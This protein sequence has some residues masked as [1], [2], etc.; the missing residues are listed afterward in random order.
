MLGFAEEVERASDLARH[1]FP[2]KCGGAPAWLEP[3]G[4]PSSEELRCAASGRPLDFLLQVYAPD[5]DA[6]ERAFHR[7][8]FVFATP[9]GALAA[10]PGAV[11]AFRCQLGRANAFYGYEPA[12][13]EQTSPPALSAAQAAA[14]DARLGGWEGA[15]DGRRYRELELVVEPEPTDEEDFDA[16]LEDGSARVVPE[17][18]LPGAPDEE[19]LARMPE[20][21]VLDTSHNPER[22][23]FADFLT[24]TQRA[25]EQV[26]RYRF[27]DG[28]R[29]LWPSPA[30]VPKEGDVPPCPRCGSPRRFEFQVLPQLLHYLG[31][32]DEATGSLDFGSV[33]VY[34]CAASCA[35]APEG[36]ASAGDAAYAEEFVWV[37]PPL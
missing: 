16:M 30:H 13:R 29:P 10:R 23:Q 37:Q 31:V 27:K 4:V 32:D 6:G 19:G 36:G 26:L 25:P 20:G 3:V 18:D 24:R 5:E 9:D 2:S 17:V 22:K 8:V 1:R 7:A 34:S 28:A 21:G 15:T 35:T 12:P 33:A 11:R 14:R